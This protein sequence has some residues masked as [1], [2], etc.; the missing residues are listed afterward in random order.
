MYLTP[1]GLATI[2]GSNLAYST[3]AAA[4]ASDGNSA[5]PSSLAGVQVT[6]GGVIASLLYVSPTQINFLMPTGLLPG[7]TTVV[8][9]REGTSAPAAPITLL[10]V[11]PALFVVDTGIA[12]EHADG[13][14]VST[15]APAQPGEV[16]VVYGTGFGKTNPSQKNGVVP[17]SAAP[18][19]MLNQLQVLLDGQALP[20]QNILYAGI[21]PGYPGLYQ[22]NVLL[23]DNLSDS[24]TLQVS[25][26]NLASQDSLQLPVTP[27]GP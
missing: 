16:I 23:P 20:P 2:Y 25:L 5:L 17:A 15:D 10:D 6:V 7:D 9:T 26:E 24:P 8:V 22:V 1:N 4:A 27:A 21:T 13:T 18:I 11:A 3:Q 19:L 12:A 14:V